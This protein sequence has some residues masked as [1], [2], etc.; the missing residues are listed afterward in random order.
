M[1]TGSNFNS[2]YLRFT[3]NL[4]GTMVKNKPLYIGSD[5]IHGIWFNGA[6]GSHADWVIGPLSN[7]VE[8]K[9]TWGYGMSNHNGECPTGS[10]KWTEHS[11][12]NGWEENPNLKIACQ[13]K[14]IHQP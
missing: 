6:S 2:D 12:K 10:N 5:N 14:E 4:N 11:S 7:L 9:Y 3:F 13:G 8:E 1:V